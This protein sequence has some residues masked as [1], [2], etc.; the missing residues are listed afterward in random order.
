MEVEKVRETL[1]EAEQTHLLA[2]WES[3]TEAQRN[4]LL[5]D[6]RS[7]DFPKLAA[8]FNR[9]RESL[10]KGSEKL[11]ASMEPLAEEY[12]GSVA[13]SSDAMLKEYEDEG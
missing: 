10:S 13:K 1:M 7:I 11:D 9:C 4:Q 5:R 2:H 12:L 6:V 8:D 3:L